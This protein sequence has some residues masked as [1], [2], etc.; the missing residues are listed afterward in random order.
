MNSKI[1]LI[2]AVA[3][4][5]LSG[6]LLLTTLL[7]TGKTGAVPVDDKKIDIS[8]I[9]PVA[10]A[11]LENGAGIVKK[12]LFSRTRGAA[13]AAPAKEQ[14]AEPAAK[15]APAPAPAPAL[16][17]HGAYPNDWPR[18][19]LTGVYKIQGE[20]AAVITGGD[21]RTV[22]TGEH[23]YRL[24]RPGDEIGGGVKLV[25]AEP[26]SALLQKNNKG[27]TIALGASPPAVK[28]K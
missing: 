24:Y 25:R 14:P 10:E 1:R 13:E 15:A 5:A 17:M 28:K 27:W 11:S 7:R 8:V 23:Y 2:V 6:V 16:E 18:L 21:D 19:K 22:S 3:I 12:D 20:Y 4:T 9:R 26:K